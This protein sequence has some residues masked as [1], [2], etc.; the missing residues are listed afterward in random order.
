MRL[1]KL[2]DWDVTPSQAVE[3]QRRLAGRV[4]ND[5]S[6]GNWKTLAVADVSY[7]RFSNLM[8]AVALVWRRTDGRVLEEQSEIYETTFPYRTGLLTFREG[9]PLLRAIARLKI[10]PDVVMIDGQGIA[11]PRRFG[12]AAH[13]GLWLNR[14]TFGVAKTRLTGEFV[15][16]RRRVGA[17]TPLYLGGEVVGAVLRTTARSKPLFISPGHRIDLPSCVAVT[18]ACVRGRRLPEPA[19]LAHERVNEMRRAHYGLDK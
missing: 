17:N 13:M 12:F 15:E 2:H 4:R 11:H 16:P 6:L 14:P 5:V 8:F 7:S 19:R 1:R 3:L 9:P 10:R 18:L